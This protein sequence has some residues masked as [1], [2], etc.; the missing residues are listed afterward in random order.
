[1]RKIEITVIVIFA[2]LVPTADNYIDLFVSGRL[3]HFYPQ[4]PIAGKYVV[5]FTEVNGTKEY[6]LRPVEPQPQYLYSL[7]TFLPVLVS[8]LFTGG[9]HVL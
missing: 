1:M 4:T 2:I 7:F 9:L 8:F 5:N 3:A 6:L